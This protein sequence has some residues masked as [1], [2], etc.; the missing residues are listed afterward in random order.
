MRYGEPEGV[1]GRLGMGM[2]LL[3]RVFEGYSRGRQHGSYRSMGL[4]RSWWRMD[5]RGS[6]TGIYIFISGAGFLGGDYR[7]LVYA[8]GRYAAGGG[9]TDRNQRSRSGTMWRRSRVWRFC[10]NGRD[11][12]YRG[13]KRRSGCGRSWRNDASP[14]PTR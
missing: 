10:W 4:R 3:E 5:R 8:S 2:F 6:F 11:G 9:G 1:C 12:G 13:G 7:Q 14:K